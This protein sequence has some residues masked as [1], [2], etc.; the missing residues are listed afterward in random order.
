MAAIVNRRHLNHLQKIAA[1]FFIISA[2]FDFSLLLVRHFNI[3]LITTGGRA[4][5]APLIHLFILV[6]VFFY[7]L[8]YFYAFNKLTLKKLSIIFAGIAGVL[9]LT[10]AFFIEG[11]SKFPSI[12]NTILSVTLILLSLLYFWQLLD[13]VEIVRLEKQPMFWISAGVL[14]YCSIN[15]FLFMLIRSLGSLSQNFWTI[16]SIINIIANSLFAIALFCKPRKTI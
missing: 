6:S 2:L 15:I 14:S 16:H 9:I 4:N 1:V 10:N 12:G 8:I 11:L 7:A 3:T 5:N 13:Q